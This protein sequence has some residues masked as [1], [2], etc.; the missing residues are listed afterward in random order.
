MM[1]L[2]ATL[3][4]IFAF[5]A[6]NIT[7]RWFH[8]LLIAVPI[9]IQVYFNSALAYGLMRWFRVPH[10]VA[11]P[12]ALIGAS[13][14][15]ELAVA[16]AITLFGAGLGRGAGHR[17]RRAGGS[18]GD[19]LGLRGL[20]PDPA[21]VSRARGGGRGRVM[22]APAGARAVRPPRSIPWR[23]LAPPALAIWLLAYLGLGRVAGWVTGDLLRLSTGTPFG[24]AVAFFLFETPKVLLLLTLVVFGVGVIRS[25]F[26][27]ERTRAHAGR[28]EARAVGNVLAAGLG[29]VTPFCSCSAVPLFIGFLTTGVPLGVTFSFLIAAPMVNEVALVLLFGLFGWKV[30]ALYLVTGPADRHRGR[31]DHRPAPDWSGTSSPGSTRAAGRSDRRSVATADLG[32]APPVR[33]TGGARHRRPGLALRAD[34]DRRRRRHPRLGARRTSWPRIMGKGAW[35]SVPLAVSNRRADVL[36]RRRDH[37]GRPGPAGEGR[38]ARHRP[39]VHDVGHRACRFPR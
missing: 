39:G 9:L 3:V 10:D 17:R 33:R 26:T 8:V 11:A 37:P 22:S 19:A 6:D 27:P 36:E 34:R 29:I 12:G 21:L 14:F 13:N 38:G 35:W 28:P 25:F 31:L 15:F 32:G 1:A 18:A 2:L 5:Q 4:L 30:A 24:G 23:W 20:Q 7:G 16:V